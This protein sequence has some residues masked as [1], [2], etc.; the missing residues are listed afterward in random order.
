M[1]AL[2]RQPPYTET[3]LN[4]LAF[5]SLARAGVSPEDINPASNPKLCP[6]LPYMDI[7][8]NPFYVIVQITNTGWKAFVNV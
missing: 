1:P 6:Y 5:R 4:K 7:A 2:R 8:K 3:V